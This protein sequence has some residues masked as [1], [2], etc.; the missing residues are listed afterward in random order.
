MKG[1][2]CH[3]DRRMSARNHQRQCCMHNNDARDKINSYNGKH[4]YKIEN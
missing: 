2:K 4:T 3:K 1:L